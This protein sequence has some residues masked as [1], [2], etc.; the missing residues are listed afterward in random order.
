MNDTTKPVPPAG[1]EP[2]ILGYL[3]KKS[4]R[5]AGPMSEVNAT[6]Y[7]TALVDRAHVTRLQ[8]EGDKF[9]KAAVYH[10]DKAD[11]ARAERDALQA[12]LT[13][14]REFLVHIKK[15]LVRNKEYAPLSHQELDGLIGHTP[16]N[17]CACLWCH[18]SAP[19]DKEKDHE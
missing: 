1:G 18:Q 9:K 12:E 17:E 8:A 6:G 4:G 11:E 14:A 13:K 7:N 5:L 15:C 3:N 10:S 19:A 2:E 16:A